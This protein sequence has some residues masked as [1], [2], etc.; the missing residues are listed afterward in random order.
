MCFRIFDQIF[1][2]ME[3]PASPRCDDLDS[4]IQRFNG[5]FKTHLIISLAGTAV[6]DNI[7]AFLLGDF[8]QLLRHQR[9]G[10]GSS[11]KISVFIDRSSFHSRPDVIFHKFFLNVE[12]ICFGSAGAVRFFFNFFKVFFLPGVA[13]YCDHFA[14]I[15]L[16]QPG[17]DNRR[18]QSAGIGEHDFLFCHVDYLH[19]S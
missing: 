13:A 3:V 19:I 18:V 17:Q 16:L 9:A 2:G 12:N 8:H 1:S 14:V 6:T 4:R 10:H 7:G 11:E 5:G 15:L